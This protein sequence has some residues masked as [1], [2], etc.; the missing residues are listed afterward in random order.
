MYAASL[1]SFRLVGNI[2]VPIEDNS[3]QTPQLPVA[4]GLAATPEI[5][6]DIHPRCPEVDG[7]ADLRLQ[8]RLVV[9][10]ID[11]LGVRIEDERPAIRMGDGGPCRAAIQFSFQECHVHAPVAA[12]LKEV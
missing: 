7:S 2:A 3:Q 11:V 1:I 4:G 5:L 12:L 10:D 9:F 8:V 6:L